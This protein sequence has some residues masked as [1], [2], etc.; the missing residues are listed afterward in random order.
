MNPVAETI[1]CPLTSVLQDPQFLAEHRV[2]TVP[3]SL[4]CSLVWPNANTGEWGLTSR[5]SPKWAVCA[6]LLLTGGGASL[7]THGDPG[8]GS[9]AG[10]DMERRHL[11]LNF[12]TA[13]Y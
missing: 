12:H 10:Q 11:G 1:S 6:P 2:K 3:A 4:H 5:I 13:S 9:H 8:E 7:R